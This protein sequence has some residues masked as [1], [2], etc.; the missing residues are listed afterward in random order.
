MKKYI[1]FFFSVA[2]LSMT[3]AQNPGDPDPSF[4]T[5]GVVNTD[6]D[7][8]GESGYAVAVQEDGK[9]VVAGTVILANLDF[10]LLRY[11]PD[12]TLDPSFDGDGIQLLDYG[13]GSN[14]LTSV[15]VLPDG[16]IV[17]AGY[18]SLASTDFAVVRYNADGTPDLT[19]SDDGVATLD[20]GSF[21]NCYD[22]SV[23]SDGKIL[24]VGYAYEGF[25]I[26]CGVARF[27]VDGS[28]D[29]S[30]DGDGK[31]YISFGA[32]G[33]QGQ[34]ILIQPDG[35]IIVGGYA[36]FAGYSDF[37]IARL[38][39][40]GS[41]DITFDGDGIVTTDF[42]SGSDVLREMILQ[43]DGK[44]VALG[45]ADN[46]GESEI[47][48]V[49]YNADG[50]LDATFSDDGMAT[51][52]YNANSE[53]VHSLVL[54]DDGKIIFS[55][56]NYSQIAFITGRI[57]SDGSL[58]NGWGTDGFSA[59]PTTPGGNAYALDLQPD[60]KLIATGV[61]LIDGNNQITLVR[62][63]TNDKVA[64]APE[65]LDSIAAIQVYP[66]PADEEFTIAFQID[67]A[68]LISI[69]LYDLSGNKVYTFMHNVATDAGMHKHSCILP[70]KFSAG[71][72]FIRISYEHTSHIQPLTLK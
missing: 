5:D 23:Q 40:D 17:A 16:K 2:M 69:A 55:F 67:H 32:D 49:R 33:A 1:L 14:D 7:D 63:L 18:A 4:G 13:T 30:F 44:I 42:G 68:A 38:N 66:N 48:L 22:L 50:S 72:Y 39:S 3:H 70:K 54:Q 51:F 31:M 15:E 19:F 56:I 26:R 27:N 6:V 43:P 20:F 41:Y 28:A 37:A 61:Q 11:L 71:Q 59:N 34:S 29:A 65:A 53:E 64:I 9:I 52:S 36:D 60:Q 24:V 47:A 8:L 25:F 21:D 12:G 35:K 46:A 57:S 45:R 62:Y 10:A 58:D